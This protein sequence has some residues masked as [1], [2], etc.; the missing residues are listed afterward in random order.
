MSY[1]SAA[2]THQ[3]HVRGNNEDRVYTDD[4]RG[5]FLV[6]DGMGGHEAGEQAAGIAA[7][8]IRA[9]LERQTGTVE[10]RLRE[11]ITLANN[12]IF[13]AARTTPAYQGM[14]CVLT[15]AVIEE[16]RVTIGHVG[17]S[18]FYRIKRGRIE[19]ITHDHSPVGER[20]DSGELT[21]AQAM[22]HPRRN[23][24]YRDV[25]SDPRAPGDEDFIEIREI[26]FEPDLALLLCSDGL[27]DALSSQEI[28]KIVEEHA[29]DRHAT[30]LALVE[31]AIKVGKDNVSVVLVEGEMFAASF[32]KSSMRAP[33]NVIVTDPAAGETTGRLRASLERPPRHVPW[34]FGRAACLVYG[35]IIGAALLFAVERYLLQEPPTPQPKVPEVKANDGI[36]AALDK[37]RSGDTIYV[38][39]GTYVGP[40][41]LKNGV[42]LV[43]R[44]AHEAVIDGEVVA[45]GVRH[46]RFEGFQVR[47]PG[48]IRIHDSDVTLARDEV[49]GANEAGVIFS[50]TSTGS[51]SACSIHNNAGAGIAVKDSSAPSIEN[52]LVISNGVGSGA[53]PAAKTLRPGLLLQSSTD[54][55]VIGNSFAGNGAEA[56]WMLEADD[57]IIAQNYFNVAGKPDKHAKFRIVVLTEAGNERR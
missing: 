45:E 55:P 9:R 31:A 54:L 4:A 13:E 15:A 44:P 20:E 18:R 23:E 6:V 21:E 38:S 22:Q 10:Q 34:F 56:I 36:S 49:S 57:D 3:G 5:I 14:A 51:I 7:E 32:G 48:G 52:N 17:D 25:G 43:A 8:R 50:G 39:A 37:A 28:L 12:H 33:R 47:G 42:N 35:L 24:V 53:R 1:L 30:V 26:P 29:G 41:H 11:A 2:T 19:K 40:V 46:V 16:G 27:S